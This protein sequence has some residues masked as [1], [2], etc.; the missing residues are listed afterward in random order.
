MPA[1]GWTPRRVGIAGLGLI[2]GSV[3]LALKRAWP[4]V[5]IVGADPEPQAARARAGMLDALGVLADLRDCDL[6]VLAA[7]VAV[8]IELLRALGSLRAAALVTDVG[9]TKRAMCAAAR[10]SASP[11][12]FVGGHPMAGSAERGAANARADLFDGATW[13][14]VGDDA[15]QADVD[16][17]A[18]VAA[19]LGAVP[20]PI[21]AEAHDRVLAAVSHLPQLVVSALMAS[22]G[23]AA[24]ASGLALAGRGLTDSTRLAATT[25]EWVRSALDTNF[26]CIEPLLAD[27]IARLEAIR[28]DRASVAALLADASRWR[29]ELVAAAPSSVEPAS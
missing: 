18:S 5:W 26:D 6:V 13:F 7:P 17:I 29:R 16:R 14:V 24:G 9:G 28:A 1:G 25:S 23:G 21:G 11:L 3:A 10:A 27:V 4:D 15:A 8:N 2:G 19:A 12:R 20:R 22:A